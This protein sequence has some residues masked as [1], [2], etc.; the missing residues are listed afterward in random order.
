MKTRRQKFHL[1][2]VVGL[3][4]GGGAVAAAE[5]TEN[6]DKDPGWDGNNNRSTKPEPRVIKQDFGFSATT[7]AGGSAP[8]EIGGFITPSAEAAYYAKK[9]PERTFNEAMSASGKVV[10]AGRQFHVLVGFFNAGTVNEWRTPNSLAIRLQ[11]RGEIFFPYVE[12]TTGRWR[13]G[14]DHPGGFS[15]VRDE[16][17]GRMQLKGFPSGPVVHQWTLRYDPNGNSG[18]GSITVTF[19]NE[20]SVC[21]LDPGHKA[22]GA[23]FNRFGLINVMKQADDGGEVWLDEVVIDGEKES[24]DKDPGWEAIQNRRT[25]TTSIIRPRFD[26][27][28][29]PT[30]HAGGKQSGEM[31]GLIFRGDGRYP[32]MMAFY[33]D[34]LEEL[35]MSRPLKAAGKVSLRRA[36]TDSDILLG[37]FHATHSLE[38]GGTDAIG[39]PPDFLGVSIGGPSRE[40]FMFTPT[41]R[42]RNTERAIAEHGPYIHPNGKPHDWTLEYSPGDG[43]NEGRITVTLD[44]ES[45][46]LR[47]PRDHVAVGARYNRFGFI[48]THTDGNGQDLYFD[49]LAYTWTQS[50]RTAAHTLRG[51]ASSIMSVAFSPDGRLLASGCRDKT[52]RLWDPATGELRA[53]LTGHEADVYAVG[54]LARWID[55]GERQRRSNDPVVGRAFSEAPP[56]DRG[57]RRCHPGDRIFARWRDPRQQRR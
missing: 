11:G 41:Y 18:N 16:S 42:L 9:I 19:D 44:G 38:S 36:V 17:N 34:R 7:H 20:T 26:F 47:V 52:V 12:Y 3:I 49:D 25:Y 14:G 27:G 1:G 50:A 2:M 10:C 56:Y 55:A 8:G 46:T 29:S 28:Y 24:F 5:R 37:F 21:N 35:D 43:T 51:H 23:T 45:A 31:G 6:F 15:Q 39:T 54:L 13:S 48:S 22:D 33:G 57:A 53:V 4:V 32:H 30:R 40:G